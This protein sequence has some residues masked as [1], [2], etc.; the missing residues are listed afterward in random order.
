MATPVVFPAIAT[1]ELRSALEHVLRAQELVDA[2]QDA[3]GER[4][5]E[6]S[7]KDFEKTVADAAAKAG[8]MA[9]YFHRIFLHLAVSR[10]IQ[11]NLNKT[12]EF[13]ITRFRFSR[14]TDMFED[15]NDERLVDDIIRNIEE[16][17]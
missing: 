13:M 3:L 4:I 1:T 12:T 14:M 17:I 16:N 6:M 7:L 2:F 8:I 11:K 10:F 9:C 15:V 5:P